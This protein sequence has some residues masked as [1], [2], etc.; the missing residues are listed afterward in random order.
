[1]VEEFITSIVSSV[2]VSGVVVWLSKTWISERLKNAIKN[3]YDQK[4]EIHKA[5][6]KAANDIELE[7]LRSSYNILAIERRIEYSKLYEKRADAITE[8][9]ALLN[10]VYTWIQEY[11]KVFVPV[12]DLPIEERRHKA[13][14]AYNKY[15]S[16]YHHNRIFIPAKTAE[17]ID[18]LNH[19]IRQVFYDFFYGIEQKPEGKG[20]SD[21]WFE[22]F[23]R[24][25]GSISESLSN[26][27]NDFRSL[28]GEKEIKNTE[29]NA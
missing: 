12:G 14:E 5:Q 21:K 20:N 28:L 18:I 17:C 11:T 6:L 23:K 25:N 8:V 10:D 13:S 3:E 9:Y 16:V 7:K 4:L 2:L 24:M 1:M 27:E 29:A 19:N 22:I 26:L 15:I